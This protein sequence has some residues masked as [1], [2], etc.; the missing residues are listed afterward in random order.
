M[1]NP[2]LIKPRKSQTIILTIGIV[3]A[4]LL[5]LGINV[6]IRQFN[7]SYHDRIVYSL[8]VDWVVV[9]FLFLYAIRIE[10]LPF[11]IWQGNDSGAGFTI[12]S[13]LV[14]YVAYILEGVI[15]S[16]PSA[17]GHRESNELMRIIMQSLKG[18]PLLIFFVSITA[19][20]TE[21]LIF[22]A[23]VLTRL[24]TFFKNS[25]FP[26]IISSIIFSALHYRYHSLREFI[27]TFLFGVVCSVYYIRY[28]N[29]HAL[30]LVHFLIDF[31][32][33]T[34]AQYYYF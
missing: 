1:F 13:V 33:F 5:P 7:L 14:L 34:V 4:A 24:S 32:A 25:Y 28:R 23:Y 20:V 10:K 15:S 3:L 9:G 17:F 26:V 11:L 12:L 22:R 8:F 2:S 31:I 21:E 30:I 18:H 29:I 6:I 16:I 27:F 19:G